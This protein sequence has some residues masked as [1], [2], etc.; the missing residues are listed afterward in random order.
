M[1]WRPRAPCPR[2]L[3]VPGPTDPAGVAGPTRSQAQSKRWR[4]TTPGLYVPQQVDSEAVD[5]RILEQAQRLG[6]SGAV[7][8]WAALRL[9]G[10][11]FFDG[12]AGDGRTV[13]PVPLA[14]GAD[15]IR[16]HAAVALSRDRLELGE[17]SHLYGIACVGPERALFD[18][19]RRLG[20]VR[21]G[22]WTSGSALCVP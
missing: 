2:G 1:D 7:T 17:I 12:L 5:Q 9:L 16:P 11:G 14:C 21:E 19:V 8:G 22:R 20:E 13:L 10:D 18:E 3:Y 4:R 15:R 6:P